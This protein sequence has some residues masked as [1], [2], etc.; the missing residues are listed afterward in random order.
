LFSGGVAVAESISPR[1]RTTDAAV[2]FLLAGA[3]GAFIG[4]EFAPRKWILLPLP[5]R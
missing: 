5:G 1:S 3:V 2:T 4:S